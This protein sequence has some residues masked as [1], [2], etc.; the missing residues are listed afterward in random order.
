MPTGMTMGSESHPNADLQGSRRRCW[1][2]GVVPDIETVPTPWL[3]RRTHS[4][5][6]HYKPNSHFSPLCGRMTSASCRS[7]SCPYVEFHIRVLML[8][9]RLC[10]FRIRNERQSLLIRSRHI[11]AVHIITASMDVR[12]A[13]QIPG[14]AGSLPLPQFM[15]PGFGIVPSLL[16]QPRR[17]AGCGAFQTVW[18]STVCWSGLSALETHGNYVDRSVA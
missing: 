17:N 2:S 1:R 4:A 8:T 7:A 10:G 12:S 6:V 14:N 11:F 15:K 18:F 3:F 9:S 13:R 5:T 16:K